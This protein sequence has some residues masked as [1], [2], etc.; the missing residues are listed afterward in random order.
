MTIRRNARRRIFGLGVILGLAIVSLPASDA[1]AY[2]TVMSSGLTISKPGV[3]PGYVIFGAPDGNAYA[4]DAKGQVARKWSSPLPNTQ[5]GYTRPMANGNLLARVQPMRA[6][7]GEDGQRAE[8][9]GADSVIELNQN[10]R[11]MWTYTDPERSLHHDEERIENGDTL[12]VCSKDL[13]RPDVSKRLLKDDCLIEVDKAGKIV[14]EWQTVDHLDELGL[15]K[16]VRAEIM[17]G[18]GG[19][20]RGLGAPAPTRGF[21]YLHMNAA[22]PIPASAGHTDPRFR[23]GNII[24]SYRYISTI[25]VV[26]KDSKKIVWKMTG[27]TIGQHNPHFIPSGVPGTGHVLVFDNGNVDENTNPMHISSRPNSRILEIDPLNNSIAWRY[28]A[29]MS[30]RPFWSFFSHYISG[31]QRQPNGKRGKTLGRSLGRRAQDDDEKHERHDRF[32]D[33]PGGQ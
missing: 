11:V 7:A 4:I 27:T 32:G 29:D 25:A 12:F 6:T 14:W 13:D 18:Y 19:D 9:T 33:Q 3:Q 30:N 1:L 15:S 22:S 16:E 28:T 8:T 5:L 24:V 2:P 26:D 21:D 17:N 23:A 31:A 20:R 10:G